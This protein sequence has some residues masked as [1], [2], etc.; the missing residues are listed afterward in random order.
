[1]VSTCLS[2]AADL[3]EKTEPLVFTKTAE[4]KSS[5]TVHNARTVLDKRRAESQA[6][7]LARVIVQ[8]AIALES[9]EQ[10]KS[11]CGPGGRGVHGAKIH[12]PQAE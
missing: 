6:Q 2:G 5:R 8:I 4:Q 3:V 10:G 9:L 1:M 11:E 12:E 7:L